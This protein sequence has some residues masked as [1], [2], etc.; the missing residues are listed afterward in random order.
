MLL[1][2]PL[3]VPH[4]RAW[5]AAQVNAR[6]A[7]HG[8]RAAQSAAGAV[9]A[10]RSVV[11][12]VGR[13]QLRPAGRQR[14]AGSYSSMAASLLCACSAAVGQARQRAPTAAPPCLVQPGCLTWAAVYATSWTATSCST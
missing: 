4:S 1:Q 13:C 2:L 7:G 12:H 3:C 14:H 5:K 11:V 6:T 10:V 9:G 8:R